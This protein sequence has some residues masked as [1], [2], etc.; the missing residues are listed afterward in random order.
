[1]WDIILAVAFLLIIPIPIGLAIH[2]KQK[3]KRE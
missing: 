3:F 2:A 1:M